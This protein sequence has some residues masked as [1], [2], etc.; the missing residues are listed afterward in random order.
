M[1]RI[2]PVFKQVKHHEM[3]TRSFTT[4]PISGRLSTMA[5]MP[6]DGGFEPNV[7]TNYGSLL[8]LLF[9][10][11]ACRVPIPPS[12]VTSRGAANVDAGSARTRTVAD[13]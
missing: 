10:A 12:I 3:P 7:I 2:E 4:G 9:N 8:R 6:T 1:N 5:S 11:K 13:P